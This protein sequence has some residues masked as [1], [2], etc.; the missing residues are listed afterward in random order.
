MNKE[1][2]TTEKLEA[3]LKDLL[4]NNRELKF[5]IIISIEGIPIFSLIPRK[6]NN[7]KIAAMVASIRSISEMAVEDMK[8][9]IFEQI[10][11]KGID[12]Y[13][14]ILGTEEAIL[15][16]STTPKAQMGLVLFDCKNASD[17]IAKILRKREIE[18]GYVSHIN[19]L[20]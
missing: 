8:I 1:N 9:G 5:A 12:G 17:K 13:L 16:V 7:Q 18:K 10:Y 19:S 2:T 20:S 4:H 11:V 3:V 6:Y 14:L 15:A